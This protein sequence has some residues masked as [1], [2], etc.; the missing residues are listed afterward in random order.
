MFRYS[1]GSLFKVNFVFNRMSLNY[2]VT[3]YFPIMKDLPILAG[4]YTTGHNQEQQIYFTCQVQYDRVQDDSFA[5]FMIT[6]VFDGLELETI[7]SPYKHLPPFIVGP[8]GD[9]FVDLTE[10][11][12]QG[13]LGKKVR[14]FKLYSCLFSKRFPCKHNAIF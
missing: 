3:D 13:R 11:Y 7:G 9:M 5:R 4:P 14:F 10:Y 8:D 2:S 12:L 1:T 6:F